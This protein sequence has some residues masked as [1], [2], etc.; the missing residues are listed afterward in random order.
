MQWFRNFK[1]MTK[2]LLGFGLTSIITLVVGFT[3]LW[4]TGKLGG[5]LEEVG[6]VRL[7]SILGLQ[8]VNEAQTAVQRAERTFM[9]PG[10]DA[11][12]LE[13]QKNRLAEAWASVDKGWKIYEPLPQT[14]EE[15]KLWKDFVPAWDKWKKDHQQVLVLIGQE[16]MEEAKALSFGAT[17]DSFLAAETLLGKLTE[18]NEEVAKQERAQGAALVKWVSTLAI[19][20]T[21]VGFLCAIG[22]GIFLARLIVRDLAHVVTQATQAATGDLT[23]RVAL[24]S[25]DELGQMGQALNTMMAKFETAMREVSQAAG[26]TASAAQQLAAGSEQLS[27]GAQ[28]QASALEETAASL[29]E[30]TGTITQNADNAKQAN[31]LATGTK[32]QAEAGGTVVTDAVAAMGAITTSS[33]QIAAIIT[34]I[35]EIAFQTN[36]LALNAAVEAARAGE[37]GRGFAVVASEVRALAQRS[38][39]ASKEIKALI[40]D[41]VAKVEAG[42]TLVTKA[43]STLTEIV[44]NVKKVADLIAEITAASAEQATGIGQVNKAVT[45]MDS[46]TQQNAAQTEE[47]SGT[48]QSLAAQA[49]ELQAQVSQFKVSGE[50]RELSAEPSAISH[51]PSALSHGPTGKVIPLKGKAKGKAPAAVPPPVPAKTGTDGDGFTEF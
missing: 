10:L 43:G 45:Q 26:H 47:L 48:A 7:P 46:V 51:Q 8:I 34:T 24:D 14:P 27:S 13:N 16:K 5:A 4:G 6:A 36:L 23:V 39:S 17:R 29:E 44:G 19:A 9:I 2:L 31:A 28:E 18:L 32:T 42:S 49:E 21:V 33:K 1:T 22:L 50:S 30:M 38:A 15:A 12:V 25:K 40:T 41:S 35:D 20:M 37:Q 3:A 11:K